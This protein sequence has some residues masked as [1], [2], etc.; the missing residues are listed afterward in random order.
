M[1]L[2]GFYHDSS[3]FTSPAPWQVFTLEH[4][5]T[6]IVCERERERERDRVHMVGVPERIGA[7]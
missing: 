3:L 7:L 6:G 4:L 2:L 1:V 5:T